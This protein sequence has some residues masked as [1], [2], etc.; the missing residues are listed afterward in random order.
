MEF[1]KLAERFEHTAALGDERNCGA[2]SS[3]ENESVA[4]GELVGG[5]YFEEAEGCVVLGCEGWRG[6]G[7]EGDVFDEGA[8]EGEDANAEVLR[9]WWWWGGHGCCDSGMSMHGSAPHR[10]WWACVSHLVHAHA[11]DC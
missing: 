8:L 3:G 5:S 10:F 9:W 7:E 11:K 2:F 6:L 1:D 4:A